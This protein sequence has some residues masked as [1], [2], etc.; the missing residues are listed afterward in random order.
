MKFHTNQ[1]LEVYEVKRLPTQSSKQ[2]R[3]CPADETV[4]RDLRVLL[5]PLNNANKNSAN[6]TKSSTSLCRIKVKASGCH[7][8]SKLLRSL[9][10]PL[11]SQQEETC[12]MNFTL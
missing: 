7:R 11:V 3:P 4:N 9:E 6:T 10:M 2:L 5:R 12:W 8:N 1:H